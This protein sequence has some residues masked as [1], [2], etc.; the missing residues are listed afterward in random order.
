MIKNILILKIGALGDAVRTT[1]FLPCLIKKYQKVKIQWIT[2]SIVY[3]LFK[4]NKYIEQVILN[5]R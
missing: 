2:S 5:R 4:Y 3:D 1:Y